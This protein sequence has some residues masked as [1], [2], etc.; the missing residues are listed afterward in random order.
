MNTSVLLSIGS[1]FLFFTIIYSS[2]IKNKLF[3]YF[4]VFIYIFIV[5]LFIALR[6]IIPGSD[7]ATYIEYFHYYDGFDTIFNS[8]FSWKGDFFFLSLIN[9]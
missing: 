8:Y 1:L 2:F 7:T 6:N 9:I 5:V 4:Q 3:Q